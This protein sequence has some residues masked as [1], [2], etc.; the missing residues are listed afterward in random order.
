MSE[1]LRSD[2]LDKSQKTLRRI[3]S[4]S[5]YCIY[6]LFCSNV[7]AYSEN[8]KTQNANIVFTEAGALSSNSIE[9]IGMLC[10]SFII[11][12]I[13]ALF[14]SHRI[15]AK[16]IKLLCV[17]I[18][19]RKLTSTEVK[20]EKG[21]YVKSFKP[22]I[23]TINEQLE[24]SS[25]AYNQILATKEYAE[26]SDKLKSEFV[27]KISHEIRTPIHSII[28]LLR[29]LAK[30]E[31]SSSKKNFIKLA[32]ESANSLLEASN[33]ILDYS[34]NESGV[35]SISICKTDIRNVARKTLRMFQTLLDEKGNIELICDIKNSVPVYLI[36]DPYRIR[37][38]LSNILSNA[39]K[40][41]SKGYIRMTIDCDPINEKECSVI[42]TLEDTGVGIPQDKV[43]HIFTPFRQADNSLARQFEG[44]GLGL[45]IVKQ[46]VDQLEGTISVQSQINK[47]TELRI[48]ARFDYQ[49]ERSEKRTRDYFNR[50][51]VLFCFSGKRSNFFLEDFFKRQ[52]FNTTLVAIDKLTYGEIL[53]VA[54]STE[55][56]FC[57]YGVINQAQVFETI[58]EVKDDPQKKIIVT[59]SPKDLQEK[60]RIAYLGASLLVMSPFIY[61]DILLTI[62]EKY[63]PECFTPSDQEDFQ[64]NHSRKLRILIADDAQTNR[65]ILQNMLERLGHEVVSVSN[66]VELFELA[67]NCYGQ[68]RTQKFDIIL[69]DIQMPHMDG[70][71][72][73]RKLRELERE[74]KIVK[75]IK[76]VAVTAQALGD[77]HTQ[78]NE[79]DFDGYI[80]KPM[81]P[82]GLAEIINKVLKLHEFEKRNID[83]P[84]KDTEVIETEADLI[85]IA[86][87]VFTEISPQSLSTKE[88]WFQCYQL[89]DIE[90]V[91]YRSGASVQITLNIFKAFLLSYREHLK[92]LSK[93]AA[94]CNQSD[95]KV[96]GNTLKGLLLDVGAKHASTLTDEL[97]RSCDTQMPAKDEILSQSDALI[98]STMLAARIIEKIY[99]AIEKQNSSV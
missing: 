41:T 93:A 82:A 84:K 75:T 37:Q 99:G 3:V 11:G 65:I 95:M 78:N 1:R 45:T 74:Q 97:L 32:Q 16:R 23:H 63:K 15:V 4:R 79:M 83:N 55:Y 61:E 5:L 73:V 35:L 53:D 70:L 19:Q 25:T 85:N 87:S 46:I 94:E 96:A 54:R 80:S 40:F 26:R 51:V 49:D 90:E 62:E 36:T 12:S 64:L 24:V 6:V 48:K 8:L 59:V 42:F 18:V 20:Q 34:K 7:Y 68:H 27:A 67:K 91:Y 2:A 56:L 66:G 17:N 14:W 50:S 44:I 22:L 57:N 13:A 71:T 72:A 21:I 33:D 31:K 77:K 88:S 60:E 29:I 9:Y 69:T 52:G 86:N 38:M 81:T 47:G 10:I 92:K 39:V 76:I 98:E 30:D 89:L 28:G 58:I 43:E